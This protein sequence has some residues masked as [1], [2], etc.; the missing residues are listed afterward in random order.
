[1]SSVYLN[2][3]AREWVFESPQAGTEAEVL[4]FHKT[5][6]EYS[7]TRLHP[8]PDLAAELGLG[9]VLLKDESNRF[10]LPS[11]KILGASWAVYKALGSRLGLPVSESEISIADLGLKAREA[12]LSLVTCTDGNCGRAISRM[13]GYLGIPVRV[14]VPKY[15]PEDT[16]ELIR[17]EGAQVLGVD[18][19]Y[20]DTIPVIQKEAE[21]QNIVM[22]LDVGLKDFDV[23][24]KYFVQGYSTMLVESE[25]QIFEMTRGRPTHAIVPCGAGSIAEAVTEHFKSSERARR[26]PPVR[27]VAVESSNAACLHESMKRGKSVSVPTEDTIMAGMNCGTLSTAAWPIL[28]AGVDASVVITDVE[29]HEAVQELKKRDILAGP[30][31]AAAI[32]ALRQACAKSREQ[33]ALDRNAVVIL[34]S[35]EGPRKYTIPV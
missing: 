32:S 29:S 14:F 2:P 3:S 7:E 34:Y 16:R 6:P 11:F 19:D 35:T 17:D 13:A 30:C 20:D 23:V 25:R 21:A 18:G 8:L 26:S 33:L 12:G 28:Q 27:V 9:H 31:G 10:G 1:M 24:P 4:A 15:I 22:I 5:L